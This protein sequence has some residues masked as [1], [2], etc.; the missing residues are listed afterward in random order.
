MMMQA[1][2][3]LTCR[4]AVSNE[5]AFKIGR[6]LVEMAQEVA[7]VHMGEKDFIDAYSEVLEIVKEGRA[8]MVQDERGLVVASLG[9]QWSNPWYAPRARVLAE[10]W[11]YVLPALR[12]GEA[13]KMLEA[14]AIA[15]A[16][17]HGKPVFL[18]YFDPV[19]LREAARKLVV[20]S[21]SVYYPAGTIAR[22]NPLSGVP[23]TEG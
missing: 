7:R 22:I 14:A 16:D 6:L 19:K 23:V 18:K 4:K 3:T 20:G 21:E 5:D 12:S 15:A 17:E 13:R 8:F 1:E 10:Q 9:L 11:F 2:R